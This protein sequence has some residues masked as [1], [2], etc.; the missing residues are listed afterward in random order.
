MEQERNN[1]KPL[2]SFLII[3]VLLEITVVWYMIQQFRENYLSGE[4]ALEIA[5]ADAGLAEK[6]KADIDLKNKDGKAWY[7]ITF[8]GG[9]GEYVYEVDAETGEILSAQK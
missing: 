7:R 5:L 9:G 4:E 2:I 8:D 6:P 3:L 1:L